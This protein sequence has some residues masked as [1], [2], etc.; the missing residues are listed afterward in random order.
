MP[1]PIE[2]QYW[3]ELDDD[4]S[5]VLNLQVG[6]ITTSLQFTAQQAHKLGSELVDSARAI[7]G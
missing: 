3:L 6:P 2:I 5:V 4:D 1:K 7:E